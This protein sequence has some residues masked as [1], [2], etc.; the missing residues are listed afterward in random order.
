MRLLAVFAT[1]VLALSGIARAQEVVVYTSYE[2][3][4]L[5]PYKARAEK[6]VPGITI[7]WVHDANGVLT[8]RLLAEKANPRADA[9]WGVAASSLGPISRH[10]RRN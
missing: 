1:A 6:D 3:E 2:R 5:A 9:V 4:D 8:A 7:R 10:T